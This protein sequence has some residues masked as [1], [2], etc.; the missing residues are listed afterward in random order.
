MVTRNRKSGVHDLSLKVK[1]R[2]GIR[3]SRF[4]LTQ[5]PFNSPIK[6]LFQHV[7]FQG[8]SLMQNFNK[9]LNW[10]LPC[11]S[12]CYRIVN[13]C[14]NK[15]SFIPVKLFITLV[16]IGS[17]L[18]NSANAQLSVT[19]VR[20]IQGDAPNLT[21][22][23]LNITDLSSLLSIKVGD[24]TY[25]S[26]PQGNMLKVEEDGGLT[27]V[28]GITLA[29]ENDSFKSVKTL[30]PANGSLY[31]LS[32]KA[33]IPDSAW[34]ADANQSFI[35]NGDYFGEW[36]DKNGQS[37][38][39][40]LSKIPTVCYAPYTLTLTTKAIARTDKENSRA[41]EQTY[42]S[43]QAIFIINPVD[44]PNI[45]YASPGENTLDSGRDTVWQSSR[46]YDQGFINQ[47]VSL[48]ADTT[49]NFPTTGA[50][51]LYFYL[52]IVG[53]DDVLSWDP[54]TVGNLT[55]TVSDVTNNR[56][57]VTLNGPKADSAMADASADP[58][59]VL[60]ATFELIGKDSEDSTKVKYVFTLKSWFIARD[61]VNATVAEQ[62]AWC[63]GLSHP[64]SDNQYFY[65]L[66]TVG[67]LTNAVGFTNNGI[68]IP[69]NVV[70]NPKGNQYWRDI[71]AGI[72]SEWGKLGAYE[73]ANFSRQK[74]PYITSN[75]DDNLIVGVD[76]N[77]GKVLLKQTDEKWSA[78][79]LAQ[80]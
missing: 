72:L 28:S 77:T 2:K 45:C 52:N 3:H 12:H 73:G 29:H 32:D 13:S 78:L 1:T 10:L 23:D 71:G 69:A 38:G 56:I 9:R 27:P 4:N 80:P 61:N 39:N 53:S 64:T 26:D 36:K 63:E 15:N 47:T 44:H 46:F 11:F 19:A 24:Q 22:N 79:C 20:Q 67:D 33:V 57:K 43:G 60:P 37:I 17:N 74:L 21:V 70:P 8:Y 6:L 31:Y 42:G 66:P 58:V 68:A 18:C 40:D 5:L 62:K 65:H 55:A 30:V 75:N 41:I 16:V 54:V 76:T 48:Q 51:G 50:D 49:D 25:I 7:D 59:S 35:L 14:F 34:L